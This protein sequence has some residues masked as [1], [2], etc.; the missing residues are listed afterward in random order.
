MSVNYNASSL[1][2]ALELL[3]E[4]L[5]FLVPLALIGLGLLAF[6]IIDIIRKKKTRSLSPLIWIIIAVAFDIIG[7][8]LYIVFGRSDTSRDDDEGDEI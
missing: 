4:L 8:V 1:D 7:P 6:V 5:P 3:V 2:E